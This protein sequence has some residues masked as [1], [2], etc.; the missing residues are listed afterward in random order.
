MSYEKLWECHDPIRDA[1]EVIQVPRW[2]DPDITPATVAAI[3]QGGC[4]SGAYMPAVT[5]YDALTTMSEYD[6]E[7]L[8]SI[9]DAYGEIPMPD[10]VTSWPGLAVYFVSLAVELWASETADQLERFFDR[11]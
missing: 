9:E 1:A 5:Y 11:G 8:Q 2:I 7:I 6:D 3:V 4:A 10:E